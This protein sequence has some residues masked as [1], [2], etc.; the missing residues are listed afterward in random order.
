MTT[1]EVVRCRK[2]WGAGHLRRLRRSP[3]SGRGTRSKCPAPRRFRAW[4]SSGTGP[5][6]STDS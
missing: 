3:R 6:H 2:W 1:A 5:S 4:C